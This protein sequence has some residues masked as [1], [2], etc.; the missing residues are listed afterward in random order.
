MWVLIK[1]HQIINFSQDDFLFLLEKLSFFR[2]YCFIELH[3]GIFEVKCAK[4][5]VTHHRLQTKFN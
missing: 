3:I 1:F 2:T 4:Y 5:N